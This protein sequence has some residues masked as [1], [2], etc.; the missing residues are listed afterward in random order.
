VSAL[1]ERLLDRAFE[2]QPVASA[3]ALESVDADEAARIFAD[4]RPALG[5][6]VLVR[7]NPD[8]A[9]D[10]LAKLSLDARRDL[11]LGIDPTR[12][13][14]L[15]ARLDAQSRGDTLKALP[16]RHAQELEEIASYP[17]NT[18]GRA[19]DVK[20]TAFSPD[21]S[22]EA[23]IERIRSLGGRRISDVML[24]DEDGVLEGIVSLQ[25]LI[26]A[27]ADQALGELSRR[28]PVTVNPITPTE[29]VVDL[30]AQHKLTSLPV[31]DLDNRLL[32]VLRHA[33]L[34]DAAQQDA[35]ADLQKM[36]GVSSAERALSSPWLAVR[37]RLPWLHVNL[38]TAFLASSIV[39]A[40][41]GTIAKLTALAVLMPVVAGE[42][43]NTGGQAMAVTMRGLA[44]REIRT[45]HWLRIVRKEM[46]VGATNGAAI[47]LTTSVAVYL[48]SRS[49]PLALVIACAMVIAMTIAAIAGATVPMV[50]TALKRDPATAA[51]IF[52]TAIT[53]MVGFATFLGLATAFASM[54]Q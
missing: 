11:I 39:S 10:V 13:A 19:M 37:T 26:G 30:L 22:V 8:D 33:E 7:M 31:V 53:D 36:V 1:T 49:L 12:A 24:I 17:T 47:A 52:L 41:E 40:F 15:L 51:S 5:S 45:S 2:R 14:S 44:L 6:E 42:S 38:V 48:W 43:G 4:R 27:R 3:R 54:L 18:A 34:V 20:V 35:V 16:E 9:A 23:A 28:E 21:T 25:D 46:V 32:G 29:E 50:L